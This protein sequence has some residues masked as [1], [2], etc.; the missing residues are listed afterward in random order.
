MKKGIAVVIFLLLAGA[1]FVWYFFFRPLSPVA[2]PSTD[3]PTPVP[4]P[5]VETTEWKDQSEFRFTYPKIL[6]LNP[7]DEDTTNYA[8]IEL[9]S[10]DHPG[11]ITVWAKDTT[12]KTI[13][14][15]ATKEKV[16]GA[17]DTT[18]AGI[19]AKKAKKNEESDA[20]LISTI[21]NGYLYQLEVL[22]TDADFWNPVFD[23]VNSSFTFF[24]PEESAG[25]AP[26]PA[27]N[28]PAAD[29]PAGGDVEEETIE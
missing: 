26:A 23:Q 13:D 2:S 5:V 4:S 21:R 18:L 15:W 11:S 8:H 20:I 16:T 25:Q 7:H 9:T 1:G 29:A 28:V 27:G 14:A 6:S 3:Q 17:I 19:P 10:A 22:P 12:A 24:T